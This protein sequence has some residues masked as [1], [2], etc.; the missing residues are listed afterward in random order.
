MTTHFIHLVSNGFISKTK[1]YTIYKE[2]LDY[3]FNRLFDLCEY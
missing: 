1:V 3:K 2:E